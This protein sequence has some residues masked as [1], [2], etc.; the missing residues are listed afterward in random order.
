MKKLVSGLVVIGA[1]LFAVESAAE[2]VFAPIVSVDPIETT[3]H[4][5]ESR[6]VC[7]VVERPVSTQVPV[8]GQTR[9]S[10][11]PIVGALVGGAL[12][13]G[14]THGSH[15]NQAAVVGAI[16]GGYTQRNK[17]RS[18]VVGYETQVSYQRENICRTESIPR[19]RSSI[20]G[21]TVSFQYDGGIQTV[22]MKERPMNDF[23]SV[24]TKM[25]VY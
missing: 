15:R 21:Y 17:T 12:A 10:M 16:L 7:E 23:V 9:D 20:G 25:T 13:R 6:R 1:T 4:Y 22:T 18:S 5:N 2:V 8:Y 14:V 24:E 11:A 19:T 3:V